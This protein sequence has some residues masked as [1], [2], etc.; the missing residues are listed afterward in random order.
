M[1]EAG[2]ILRSRRASTAS[3]AQRKIRLISYD[4][5][6]HISDIKLIRTDTTLDLSQKAEKNTQLG[7]RNPLKYLARCPWRL[8]ATSSRGLLYSSHVV[9]PRRPVAPP[10]RPRPN[11]GA[12]HRCPRSPRRCLPSPTSSQ[13]ENGTGWS[14]AQTAI[15]YGEALYL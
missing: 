10:P 15:A 3:S 8:V 4:P 13:A 2:N 11:A 12:P 5:M 1:C 14:R 6:D 9:P 7:S